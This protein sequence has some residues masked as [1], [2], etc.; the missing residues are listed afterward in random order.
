[1]S[2][3]EIEIESAPPARLKRRPRSAVTS[4]RKQFVEGDPNSAW[5]RR[6]HDLQTH[7]IHDVSCGRGADALTT[8]HLAII[9]RAVAIQ[10]ELERLDGCLS[11]SEPV[12]MD[13]Y[14]RVSSHLRRHLETLG[15]EHRMLPI[16]QTPDDYIAEKY[17]A[18]VE[19]EADEV[20]DAG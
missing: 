9:D 8:A 10:C 11:R 19:L 4:G 12:C 18:D 14:S 17:G 15:V 7:Y 3:S 2:A 1:V 20:V 6:Y 16:N 5:A 13:L